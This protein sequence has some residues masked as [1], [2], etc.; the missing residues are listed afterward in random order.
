M[1]IPPVSHCE[2]FQI[3][4]AASEYLHAYIS[5][6]TQSLLHKPSQPSEPTTAD[7]EFVIVEDVCPHGRRQFNFDAKHP[8]KN[9]CSHYWKV[10]NCVRTIYVTLTGGGGSGAAASRD[11]YLRGGGGGGGAASIIK[12]PL[13]VHEGDVITIMV[14]GGGRENKSNMDGVDGHPSSIH[15]GAVKIVA[16]NGQGGKAADPNANTGG[17]GGAGGEN[18]ECPN[19]SGCPGESGTMLPPSFGISCGGDGGASNFA[20]GG[21]GG[22]GG[23]GGHSFFSHG[24]TGGILPY[25]G[26]QPG[27]LGSGG[28]G[29]SPVTF[30]PVQGGAGGDGFVLIQW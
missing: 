2:T 9:Y 7:C 11:I 4:N 13:D 29:S 28:G 21:L 22:T 16:E 1:Q 23:S 12:R 24:G 3:S 15:Y 6:L 30:D 14:G 27:S 20:M 25:G 8:D 17:R 5:E 18:P 10:P 26:G 19:Q